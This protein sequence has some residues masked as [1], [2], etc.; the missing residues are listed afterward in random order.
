MTKGPKK[1]MYSIW[2]IVLGIKKVDF[3]KYPLNTSQVIKNKKLQLFAGVFSLFF[4]FWIHFKIVHERC[5][6]V[7]S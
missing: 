2:E 3:L 4:W 7:P 1:V 5:G 6:I